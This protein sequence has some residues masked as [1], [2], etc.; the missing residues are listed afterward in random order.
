MKVIIVVLSLLIPGDVMARE[1]TVAFD[2]K[3][4]ASFTMTAVS[5]DV[6]SPMSE[7]VIVEYP[8]TGYRLYKDGVLMCETKDPDARSMTCDDTTTLEI[9]SGPKEIE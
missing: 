8:V 6:E 1:I 7:P 3:N 5:G 9:V 2:H 4:T